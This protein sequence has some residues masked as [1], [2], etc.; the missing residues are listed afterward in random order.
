[1]KFNELSSM[2]QKPEPKPDTY[3]AGMA[4]NQLLKIGTHAIKIHNMIDNNAEMEAWVAK[5][6]DL[7]SN[8]V[9]SVHGYTAGSKAGTYNDGGLTTEGGMPASVIKH[10]QKLAHMSDE[11][12]AD[13]FKDF[14][15]QRLRQMAWRHGYGK[16]SS[17][18]LDRVRNHMT[19]KRTGTPTSEDAQSDELKRWYKN[20]S[21]YSNLNGDKLPFGLYMQL[22]QTG[23][24]TD[25]MAAHE[26]SRAI[27]DAGLD[28]DAE[29]NAL[30]GGPIDSTDVDFDKADQRITDAMK[31][32]LADIMGVD[33]IGEEEVTKA[34]KMLG[35][36]TGMEE[37]DGL[38]SADLKRLGQHEPKVYVHKDGKTIMVPKDQANNYIAKGWKKSALRAET[39]YESKLA[40][41]L[42]QRLK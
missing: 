35:V 29:Q 20:Y 31:Q 30:S 1:M 24:P 5:K 22:S 7:A 13:R 3:E 19:S 42:N 41:M 16:M 4:L 10:K 8:Y 36:T 39:S 18:Y 25:G 9:K 28:A 11:E 2:M 12:L 40:D 6:I 33:A 14:D 26:A 38:Q 27:L 34:M 17:H 37:A 21:R 32:E 23:V 15:E